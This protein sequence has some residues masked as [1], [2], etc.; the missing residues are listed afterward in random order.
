MLNILSTFCYPRSLGPLLAAD[1]DDDAATIAATV[2]AVYVPV[3]TVVAAV[4]MGVSEAM[5]G[6][7]NW[8]SGQA[9]SGAQRERANNAVK[10]LWQEWLVM[11]PSFLPDIDTAE[12]YANNVENIL[13]VLNL[14]EQQGEPWRTEW[15]R[16]M[17]LAVDSSIPAA[18]DASAMGW[19]PVDMTGW[20]G[21]GYYNGVYKAPYFDKPFATTVTVTKKPG[22]LSAARKTVNTYLTPTYDEM[23][24]R[25]DKY[26]AGVGIAVACGYN[27]AIEPVVEAAVAGSRQW[28]A[29]T[30]PNMDLAGFR[31][32]GTFEQAVRAAKIAPAN[33][34][35]VKRGVVDSRLDRIMTVKKQREL[36]RAALMLKP[37]SILSKIDRR[38]L[39][40]APLSLQERGFREMLRNATFGSFLKKL[41]K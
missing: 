20:L 14:S 38:W 39:E 19:F 4:M 30:G 40:T 5:I 21:I 36:D 31:L 11:P 32:K 7:S 15:L 12:S 2:A 23:V 25:T 41:P 34:M 24:A 35:L 37:S 27:V 6:L 13:R 9:N 8:L 10:K 16:T 22:F 1:D 28:L 33:P 29:A 18:R 3:G 26:A 17:L